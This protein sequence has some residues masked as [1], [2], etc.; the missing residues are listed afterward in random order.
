L[1]KYTADVPLDGQEKL[2]LRLRDT[3]RNKLKVLTW[4]RPAPA[5][6]RLGREAPAAVT[7]LPPFVPADIRKNLT[8]VTTRQSLDP[9]CYALALLSALGSIVLRRL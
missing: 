4:T 1:G 7:A 6:Y 2:T 8:P 3:D 9:W 5:E